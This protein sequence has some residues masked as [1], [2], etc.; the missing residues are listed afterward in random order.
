M[1]GRFRRP[2]AKCGYGRQHCGLM[3]ELVQRPEEIDPVEQSMTPVQAEI[4][5]RKGESSNGK[6]HRKRRLAGGGGNS[7][8]QYHG[9]GA[10]NGRE[11]EKRSHER[12]RERVAQKAQNV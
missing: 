8:S 10:R 11:R 3:M 1:H 4:A 5:A 6:V 7:G 2:E 9:S 12:L